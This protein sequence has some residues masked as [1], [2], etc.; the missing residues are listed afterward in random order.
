MSPVSLS[1]AGINRFASQACINPHHTFDLTKQVNAD[2]FYRST[3]RSMMPNVARLQ[4]NHY[5]KRHQG[6]NSLTAHTT[7]G[8]PS[9]AFNGLLSYAMLT[10]SF[11]HR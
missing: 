5:G 2:S 7:V 6:A 11:P 9:S 3:D 4:S 1:H 10:L 8:C